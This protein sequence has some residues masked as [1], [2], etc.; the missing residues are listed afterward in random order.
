MPGDPKQIIFRRSR[1]VP[2][3]ELPGSN[4]EPD[5]AEVVLGNIETR[6]TRVIIP[7]NRDAWTPLA[8]APSRKRLV[9]TS[10]AGC[11]KKQPRQVRLYLLD[12][13]EGRPGQPEP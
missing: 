12:L 8:V 13:N 11:E 6:Q 5:P 4:P 3:V 1:A 2:K 10:T 7:E 9:L